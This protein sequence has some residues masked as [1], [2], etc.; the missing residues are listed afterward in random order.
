M[1]IHE[2]MLCNPMYLQVIEMNKPRKGRQRIVLK[3]QAN[4]S[5][6]TLMTSRL[7]PII[8]QADY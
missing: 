7:R 4:N 5:N 3:V 2:T 8:T 6:D 1:K